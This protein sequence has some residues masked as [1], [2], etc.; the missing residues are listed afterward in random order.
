MNLTISTPLKKNQFEALKKLL[1]KQVNALFMKMGRGKSLVILKIFQE[2]FN[3]GKVDKMVLFLPLATKE[4][5]EREIKKHTSG[6]NNIFIFGIES[7]SMSDRI[8]NE[9]DRMVNEKTFLVIDESTK[10]KNRMAIRT[11]RVFQLSRKCRYKLISTGTPITK[12]I[13]DLYSQF[14]ILSPNILGYKTY[15]AFK[16]KHLEIN[17]ITGEVVGSS[18]V[19]YIKKLIEPFT[20]YSLNG[21]EKIKKIYEKVDYKPQTETHLAYE[22]IKAEYISKYAEN[23]SNSIAIMSMLTKLQSVISDENRVNALLQIIE[24]HSEEKIIIVCK[25]TNSIHHIYN[26]LP[27]NAAI[28]NGEHKEINDFIEGNKN[29]LITNI[30]VGALGLN[31]Q[32]ANVTIFYENSFDYALRIQ[33]EARTAREGQM[34]DC[35]YYDINGSFGI[36]KMV[37]QSIKKKKNLL[38]EFKEPDISKL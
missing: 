37:F 1:P 35:T 25:Y 27:G 7:I 11:E 2:R 14:L 34:K 15:E 22:K 29:I 30:A 12:Y 28:L 10:V 18:N 16:E 19:E 9:V 33:A 26:A 21:K 24:K 20:F 6:I 13:K 38:E 4:N 5:F 36:E 17:R 32:F 23:S 31:L 8:Y 3:V